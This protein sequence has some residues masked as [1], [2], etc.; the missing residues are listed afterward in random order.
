MSHT[1][2]NRDDFVR[3]IPEN[4]IVSAE[5]AFVDRVK[6]AIGHWGL[7]GTEAQVCE[8][9]SNLMRHQV[10]TAEGEL[11]QLFKG[12]NLLS[13]RQRLNI[14][15]NSSKSDRKNTG[16]APL[17]SGHLAFSER[18]D[19]PEALREATSRVQ[20]NTS[21]NLTRFVQAQKIKQKSRLDRPPRLLT[22]LV[23]AIDIDTN[24]FAHER[25]LVPA[26][27]LI[28]GQSRKYDYAKLKT[29]SQHLGRYLWLADAALTRAFED[30]RADNI[31]AVQRVKYYSLQEIEIYWEFNSDSPIRFVQSIIP[32]VKS[33][34]DQ[35][36]DGEVEID[37][38]FASSFGSAVDYQSPSIK[39]KLSKGVWLKIYAKTDRRVRFEIELESSV[40]GQ[41]SRSQTASTR[42]ALCS[43]LPALIDFATS[44]L[45]AVLPHILGADAAPS[46]A[47][48]LRLLSDFAKFTGDPDIA[49]TILAALIVFDRIS[50]YNNSP[51]MPYVHKLRDKGY[52][53]TV[54]S[55]SRNY[56]I[57]DEYRGTLKKLKSLR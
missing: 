24:W 39:A 37:P 17:I 25:P 27:N 16:T 29:P 18:Y 22:P 13:L 55:G 43:K 30:E 42:N 8:Q 35:F 51:L 38:N 15:F 48:P 33:L 34:G 50:L 5:D 56:V 6:I 3:Q 36:Y 54:K 45:N 52:L 20:F 44:R 23:L 26:T 4:A 53:R 2:K 14:Q 49:E 19:R 9:I 46:T 28:I 32:R 10:M 1:L 41:R 40:I 11:I 31:P 57:C 21:L 12:E 47:S 7:Y